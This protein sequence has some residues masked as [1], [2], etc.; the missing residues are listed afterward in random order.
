MYYADRL[1][2][3]VLLPGPRHRPPVR[4]RAGTEVSFGRGD[5]S[6]C[7]LG[8]ALQG[9][10]NLFFPIGGVSPRGP[11]RDNTRRALFLTVGSLLCFVD[12]PRHRPHV[13]FPFGS[14]QLHR[15]E[16]TRPCWTSSFRQVMPQKFVKLFLV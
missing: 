5:L 3:L 8:G 12:S 15:P 1:C 7:P 11:R 4:L 10:M 9:P 6:V 14:R 13:W 2:N 16:E